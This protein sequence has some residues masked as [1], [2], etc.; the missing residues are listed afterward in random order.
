M[1]T[2]GRY[3]S[4]RDG[5]RDYIEEGP[6]LPA[7]DEFANELDRAGYSPHTTAGYLRGARH[8]TWCIEHRRFR[9]S[10]L[11]LENLRAFARAPH[12][13]CDCA[14][15][16]KPTHSAFSAMKPF[17]RILQRR[18][19]APAP[20]PPPFASELARFGAYLEE[21]RGVADETRLTRLRTLAGGLG[22]LMPAGRFDV[23]KLTVPAINALVASF[24]E[25]QQIQ[26]ARWMADTLRAFCRYLDTT[27]E[28]PR[29]DG[30]SIRGPKARK[31][32]PL[33]KALT[34]EQLRLLLR[35]LREDTPLAARDLA[36]LLVLARTGLRRS[37]VARLALKDF[38]GR[39]ATLSVRR[40]KSRRAHEVPLPSE[41]RDALLTYVCKYR[42]R[43][44]GDALFHA[45]NYPYDKGLTASAVSAIVARAFRRSGIEHVSMGAHTLRHSL[46]THLVARRMPLK[47]IA[48]VLIHKSIE[49][50]ALYARLDR[51]RLAAIARPWPIP[52]RSPNPRSPT[53]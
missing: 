34:L 31:C 13:R 28:G 49:T 8:L 22:V 41:A 27:G 20:K 36:V 29:I 32:Q 6:L 23:R 2:A 21:V 46:A 42:P 44:T 24:A 1:T 43:R 52:A 50:T 3:F 12:A 19:I 5:M 51:Q 15:P 39:A 48:D 30:K 45:E 10:D 14:F 47:S 18:G 40:N 17:L 16:E 26:K 11:T 53:P 25:K 37:D 33:A 7:L 35:P 38:D 9:R 4:R